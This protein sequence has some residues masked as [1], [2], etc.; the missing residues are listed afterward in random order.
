[1]E[2]RM[3][4]SMKILG[5]V[6]V[7]VLGIISQPVMAED[8]TVQDGK[9]VKIDYTLKM[10]GQVIETSVDKEPL[11][12]SHGAGQII[13]G[14]SAGL[15]GMKVGEQK[16]V[17]VEPKDAY[18]DVIPEN[19]RE[20]PKSNFPADAKPEMGMV[21]QLKD[22]AGNIIPGILWEI[23]EETL[24]VNFNHPLAG[25][26]LEFDVKVVAIE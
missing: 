18:G 12:Y 15:T 16:T 13:P 25:K 4:V 26:T 24:V 7:G 8:V 14:L 19:F 5:L 17:I 20:I 22:E 3:K 23:K 10:D 2:N 21:V 1:M 6:L 11:E 9:K